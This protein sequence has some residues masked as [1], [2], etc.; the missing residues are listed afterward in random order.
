MW[1][2]LLT[3]GDCY[4]VPEILVYVRFHNASISKEQK[5]KRFVICFEHYKLCKDVQ[6][7]RYNI[8]TR[9]SGID[10]AVKRTAIFCIKH[11]MLRNIPHLHRKDHRAA[12]VKAWK[13]A[14][15]E[16]LFTT[17][18]SELFKGVER[19]VTRKFSK[20]YHGTPT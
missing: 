13:I 18:I 2:R 11:A 14:S 9:D 12:F 8:D 17:S 7:G 19:I 4:V 15:E 20:K 16:K 1:M 3:V 6:Q 10:Q 5:S